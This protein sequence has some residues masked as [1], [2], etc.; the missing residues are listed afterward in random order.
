MDTE[1]YIALFNTICHIEF[2]LMILAVTTPLILGAV[3]YL[4]F[5]IK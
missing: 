5:R 4:T 3:F 1:Q 2:Y